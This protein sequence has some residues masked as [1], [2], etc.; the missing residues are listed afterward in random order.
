MWISGLH[1]LVTGGAGFVGSHVV[2]RLVAMG[3]EVTIVDNFSTGERAN[4]Q[5]HADNPRV[6]V[7]EE[8][9]RDMRAMLEATQGVDVVLH[10]AVACVRASINDPLHVHD[11]NATGTLVPCQAS[12]ENGVRRFVYVSSTEVYGNAR[13]APVDEE[14]PLHPTN[15]YGASKAAGEMYALSAW[16]THGLPACVVR[17]FNVYGPREHCQGVPA[18]VIPRFVMRVLAGESPVIFGT[19]QQ[20]RDF[21]WVDDTVSGLVGAAA[22][23]A[24]VGDI[25][26]LGRGRE[27]SVLDLAHLVLDKLGREDLSPVFLEDGRPGDVDHLWADTRKAERLFGY[28]PSVDIEDGLDRYIAWVREHGP[29]PLEWVQQQA[30]R[31]W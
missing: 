20:T 23:D 31:N 18:E 6:H 10:M 16:R 24:L 1:C 30:L 26:H 17:L 14:H 7:I 25:V 5:H 2:D 11:V 3:N 27:V 8:D 12:L 21:T 9:V 28:R 13:Y 29:E 19:G 22:C 15:A 4:I